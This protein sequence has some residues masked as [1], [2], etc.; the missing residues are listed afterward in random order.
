MR[1]KREH[2]T[3]GRVPYAVCLLW[4]KLFHLRVHTMAPLVQLFTRFHQVGGAD[5]WE[6]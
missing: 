2:H 1:G 6:Q 3:G 5:K 4:S